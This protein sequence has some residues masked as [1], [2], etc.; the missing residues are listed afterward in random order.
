MKHHW[1]EQ[2]VW[3]TVK[4]QFKK[5]VICVWWKEFSEFMFWDSFNYDHK[6]SCY[7]WKTETAKKKKKS[8]QLIDELN[9]QNKSDTKIKWELKTAIRCIN[10]WRKSEECASKWKFDVTHETMI[11]E[12][13]EDIDVW[14]YENLIL[15]KKLLS[16]AVKCMQK[17]QNTFVQKNKT[18]FHAFK[19]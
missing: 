6:E 2:W 11:W 19:H 15:K 16:F 12:K 18:L 10:L 13:K 5:N 17:W 1:K 3:Q 7:I 14:C 4:K 8:Q 9:A